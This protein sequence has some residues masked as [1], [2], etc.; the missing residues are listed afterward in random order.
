[1]KSSQFLALFLGELPKDP[2]GLGAYAA[3]GDPK[4]HGT[5]FTS[6]FIAFFMSV[7]ATCALGAAMSLYD[8]NL[9]IGGLVVGMLIGS[10][11]VRVLTVACTLRPLQEQPAEAAKV[12]DLLNSPLV[13]DYRA[14]VIASGRPFLVADVPNMQRLAKLE[15]DWAAYEK[16][17]DANVGA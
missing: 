1:M 17:A 10:A 8:I 9:F 11:I 13:Q 5:L 6:A 3:W 2:A 16:V 14:R 12:V 15:A 4:V 7:A